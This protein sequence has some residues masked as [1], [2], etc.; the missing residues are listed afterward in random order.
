MSRWLISQG[1]RRFAA[2]DLSELKQLATDGTILSSDMIQ[3]PGA[4]EWLYAAEITELHG[5]LKEGSTGDFEDDDDWKRKGKGGSKGLLILVLLVLLGGGGVALYQAI[6]DMPD[7]DNMN[8]LDSLALTE[9]LVTQAQAPLLASPEGAQRGTLIKNSKLQLMGKQGAWYQVR[10]STGQEGYVAVD[11]VIPGYFFADK[12]T[13]ENYDP[14]YNPDHYVFVKN[15]SWLQLDEQNRNLTIFQFLLQNKSKFA[16]T[17]IILLATIKDKHGK[18]LEKVEI[19]IEG[20]IPPYDSVMVGA[21]SPDRRDRDG[22]VRNLT[23]AMFDE[24]AKQ[25]PDL[26]LRWSSG[27]EVEMKTPGFTEANID[28]LQLRGIP[29]EKD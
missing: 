6:Q 11:H 4:S 23:Q 27:I 3:P 19:P 1:D 7:Y 12:R 2:K 17:D 10:D 25:D 5:L 24:M 28:L 14:L 15:S 9:M 29:M 26:Q 8:I 16:M 18:M 22:V 20:E 13:Q 21:L